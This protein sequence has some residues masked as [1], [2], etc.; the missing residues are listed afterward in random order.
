LHFLAVKSACKDMGRRGASRA[1]NLTEGDDMRKTARTT[2]G[3]GIALLA[4]LAAIRVVGARGKEGQDS[5]DARESRQCSVQTL[6]G[7]YGIQIS[8]VRPSAPGGPIESIIGVAIRTY[9]GQGSFEQVDNV[10][11]SISGMV[12]DRQGFGTYT[13]NADC[14]GVAQ[15]QPSPTLL[16]EERFGIVN[17]G[18]EIRSM[19]AL[20]PPV[21]VTGTY[22]RV[23]R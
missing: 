16:L 4:T 9:D 5:E 7:S 21:M 2:F 22:K 1:P 20:P 14:S 18:D 23:N 11:G 15:T 8:G 19:T 10:K 17:D 3:V 13:V 12:P 6:K